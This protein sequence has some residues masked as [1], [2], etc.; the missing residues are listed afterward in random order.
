MTSLRFNDK[1]VIRHR[2]ERKT[3][4]ARRR[5]QRTQKTRS[6]RLAHADKVR[7]AAAPSPSLRRKPQSTRRPQVNAVS[8]QRSMDGGFRHN[9]E[10]TKKSFVICHAAPAAVI[11]HRLERKATSAVM[12]EGYE[13]NKYY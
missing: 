9:D 10:G 7:N 11:R 8:R 12:Q 3:V 1:E 5:R 6:G 2:L 4:S 13:T